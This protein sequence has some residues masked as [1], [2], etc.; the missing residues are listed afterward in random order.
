MS[1]QPTDAEI[2]RD[3]RNVAEA[4]NHRFGRT[5]AYDVIC[6]ATEGA[7]DSVDP[8]TNSATAVA[9]VDF[10]RTLFNA[11]L[12]GTY[13]REELCT[14]ECCACKDSDGQ[15]PEAADGDAAT[16]AGDSAEEDIT[17][18]DVL[19]GLLVSALLKVLAPDDDSEASTPDD[20]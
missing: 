15:A 1:T 12:A 14:E 9:A 13:H 8:I 10:F 5:T 2:A 19:A 18:E 4:L 17:P 3:V 7:L 6:H 16:E 11:I 20:K